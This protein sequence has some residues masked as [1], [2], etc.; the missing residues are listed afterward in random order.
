MPVAQTAITDLP[1][2][3]SSITDNLSTIIVPA[4]LVAIGAVV[5]AGLVIFGAKFGIR[6]VKSFFGVVAK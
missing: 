2:L 3:F 4:V 1:S 5:I 6:A